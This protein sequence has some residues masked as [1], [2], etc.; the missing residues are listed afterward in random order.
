MVFAY[1]VLIHDAP[2]GSVMTSALR[3]HRL[4]LLSPIGQPLGVALGNGL[5]ALLP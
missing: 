3:V 1:K 2:V 4:G 5:L